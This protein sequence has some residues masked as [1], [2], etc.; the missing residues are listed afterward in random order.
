MWRPIRTHVTA[1]A[2]ALGA[3]AAPVESQQHQVIGERREREPAT[4]IADQVGAVD[5][6]VGHAILAHVTHGDRR[7][8]VRLRSATGTDVLSWWFPT[9]HQCAPRSGVIHNRQRPAWSSLP[10]G[11]ASVSNMHPSDIDSALASAHA[12]APPRRKACSD[13]FR[14][15]RRA[16]TVR[17]QQ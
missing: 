12:P 4:V 14:D 9:S 13:E 10:R 7:P 8:A 2:A 16:E 17:E 3:P 1:L 11:S 6:Q 15:N 5:Q